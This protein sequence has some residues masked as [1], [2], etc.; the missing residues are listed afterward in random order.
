MLSTFFKKFKSK[1][2][3]TKALEFLIGKKIIKNFE[4]VDLERLDVISLFDHNQMIEEVRFDK[5]ALK[6]LLSIDYETEESG[7]LVDCLE[8]HHENGDIRHNLI[9]ENSK[10]EVLILRFNKYDFENSNNFHVYLTKLNSD[11][12]K[13]Y[14]N[15]YIKVEF[16]THE[17]FEILNA[18][19]GIIEIRQY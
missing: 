6:A 17:K 16:R 5:A 10:G 14:E 11:G 18:Y 13:L 8:L 9:F 12:S 3:T 19:A 2:A 4:D 15:G 7:I 1:D